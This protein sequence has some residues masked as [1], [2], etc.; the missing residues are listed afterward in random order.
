MRFTA[1]GHLVSA[2]RLLGAEQEPA[3]AG[4]VP[5]ERAARRRGVWAW[6]EKDRRQA[7]AAV[8]PAC[9]RP[10]GAFV[11]LLEKLHATT[12]K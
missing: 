10:A 8:P 3:G 6:C 11:A 9:C 5:R 1:T 7:A 4:A 12:V 2:G